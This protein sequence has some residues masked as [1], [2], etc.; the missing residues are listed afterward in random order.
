MD[1]MD[2]YN[3]ARTVPKEAMKPISAGRLKG[4]T[5]I[6]PMWRIRILTELFG[7]CGIGWKPEIVRQWTETGAGGEV[8]A[9]CNINL[10]IKVDGEW[11]DAIPGTGGSM[12]VASERNGPHTS[13]ECYKMAYTDA[14]SVACKMLGVGADVYWDRDPTKYNQSPD[15]VVCTECGK[16]VRNVRIKNGSMLDA[17][18][19]VHKSQEEF[20]KVLCWRCLMEARKNAG[21][22]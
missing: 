11:S 15:P 22:S 8:C 1:K 13:D 12:L 17:R 20:G 3:V 19:A 14:L 2:I 18:E 5:D 9:M 7:P 6:N 10:Y 4:M 16:E 21:H